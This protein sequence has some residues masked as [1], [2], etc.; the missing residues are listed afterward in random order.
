MNVKELREALNNLSE[1]DFEKDFIPNYRG[2]AAKREGIVEQFALNHKL[3]GELCYLLKL[4]T[5]QEKAVQTSLSTAKS[6][7]ESAI[8]SKSVAQSAKW[9]AITS[10]IFAAIA[11]VALAAMIL[12]R[13]S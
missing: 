8:A 11:L 6:A 9:S 1:D 13:P 4:P 2:S 7:E 5:E 3:E 12:L 10:V